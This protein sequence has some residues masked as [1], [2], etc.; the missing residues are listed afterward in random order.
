MVEWVDPPPPLEDHRRQ[1]R[2]RDSDERS[3]SAAK[4]TA[5][6]IPTANP[7]C[8]RLDTPRR[9]R[10][11]FEALAEMRP[12]A[13]AQEARN[14]AW[15]VERMSWALG[16]PMACRVCACSYRVMIVTVTRSPSS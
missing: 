16:P 1:A 5:D 8:A 11:R 10:R 3:A 13:G 14:S 12:V 6:A 15:L 9:R 4:A 7:S 2:L